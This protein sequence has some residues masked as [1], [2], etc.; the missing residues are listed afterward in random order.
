MHRP[1]GLLALDNTDVFATGGGALGRARLWLFVGEVSL[2][3]TLLLAGWS[4]MAIA[5]GRL[6]GA[7]PSE[8]LRHP[9][10]AP[11]VAEF[12]RRFHA[13]LTAWLHD[14]L[15][16]PLGRAAAAV[17]LVFLASAAWHGWAMTKILGYLGFPPRAWRGLLVWAVLNAAAVIGVHALGRRGEGARAPG[18]LG[19]AWRVTATAVFVSLA[20]LPLLLPQLDGLRDLGAIYLLLFGL[21]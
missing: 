12:W 13:T 19:T 17:L 10:R 4:H 6:A 15:Y 1:A 20:W 8:N 16:A 14:S 2:L 18:G 5:L 11:D 7:A 3:L 9:W 21:R